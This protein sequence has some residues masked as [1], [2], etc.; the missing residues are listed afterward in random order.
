MQQIDTLV[1]PRREAAPDLRWRRPD[2]WHL[3]TSFMG[4]VPDSH[5]ERLVEEL[6]AAAA[7]TPRFVVRLSGGI[8][9]PHAGKAKILA[10]AAH[11]AEGGLDAL[12]RRCRSA[13]N[14]AGVAVDGATFVGHLTLARHNRGIEAT[15]WLGILDSFP[16]W[17]WTADELVLIES[18]QVGRHY[19]VVERFALR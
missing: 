8:A 12:A 5:L 7:R 17:S 4:S 11:G 18:H 1:E 14:N 19:E 10:L 15:R 9:F 6:G 2:G 16:G 13:A 3:T